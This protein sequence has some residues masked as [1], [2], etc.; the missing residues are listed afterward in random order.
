MAVEP[1]HTPD[2]GPPPTQSIY[3]GFAYFQGRI[4]PFADAN[5]SVGTHAL[6]YGTACFECI[7]GY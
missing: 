4:V 2:T 6:N 1:L 7:R 5:V 3:G